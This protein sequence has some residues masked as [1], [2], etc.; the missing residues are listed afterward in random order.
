MIGVPP[1]KVVLADYDPDW[2]AEFVAERRILQQA[3]TPFTPAIEHIGSTAVPG[4]LA[5]PL[6]DIMI[7]IADLAQV[8]ACVAPMQACGYE[9]KGE[10]GVPDR[11]FFLKGD[12]TTHHVHIVA[13]SGDHW[14][15]YLTFRDVLRADLAV[16]EEYA[17]LKRE[18]AA[19]HATNRDAYTQGKDAF[20]RG[21]LA[22]SGW[23]AGA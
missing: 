1:G 11:H 3:L 16:A 22:R 12:P 19:Q 21:V 10:F 2:P 6:I 7:G 5:K 15:S 20:I 18:L 13:R 4:L 17:V 14:R 9:Y 23:R 8:A